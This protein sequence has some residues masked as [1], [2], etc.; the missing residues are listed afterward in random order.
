MKTMV[1]LAALLALFTLVPVLQ[2]SLDA[3]L[4]SEADARFAG[5]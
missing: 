4:P 5:L 3:Q 1:R 2:P